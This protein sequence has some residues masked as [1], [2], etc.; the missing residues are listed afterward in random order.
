MAQPAAL[1][2]PSSL[3]LTPFAHWPLGHLILGLLNIGLYLPVPEP[4]IRRRSVPRNRSPLWRRPRSRQRK[5]QRLS[6]VVSDVAGH[7]V[8]L[9][10]NVP[11]E[12]G[13]VLV[14]H[15]NID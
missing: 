6:G 9:L 15:Q 7:V 2:I 14:G 1:V 10:M 5:Y 11:V 13:Y 8:M 12:D 4:P 3:D